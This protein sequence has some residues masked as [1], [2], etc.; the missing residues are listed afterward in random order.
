MSSEEAKHIVT[1]GLERRKDARQAGEAQLEQYEQ[2]QIAACNKNCADARKQRQDEEV[3]RLNREQLRARRRAREEAMAKAQAREDAAM[4]AVW[5]YGLAC[6][7]VLWVAAVTRFP[8]WAAAALIAG[9]AV[10]LAAYVFRLY[11]PIKEETR[12]RR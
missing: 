12:C 5:Y 7:M 2:D 8:F 1:E 9:L 11:Y 3:G 4:A 6:L 10:F